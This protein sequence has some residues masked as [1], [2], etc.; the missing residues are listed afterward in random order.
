VVGH[1]DE[2]VKEKVALLAIFVDCRDEEAGGVLVAEDR[3]RSSVEVVT[4]NVRLDSTAAKAGILNYPD[5]PA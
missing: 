2:L 5:P 3:V 1:H 4:K